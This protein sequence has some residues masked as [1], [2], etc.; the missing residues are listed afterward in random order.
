[1]TKYALLAALMLA[2][3]MAGCTTQQAANFGAVASANVAA[4]N[5]VNNALIQLSTTV[6][7]N[8]AKL[9]AALAETYCPLVNASVSLGKQVA[10]DPNVS[11]K[12]KAKLKAAGPAGALASDVCAAAGY[13]SSATAAQ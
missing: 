6:I 4:I 2:A 1:M 13:G 7:N 12:V 5:S 8:Q 11:A 10:D 3:F 9:A